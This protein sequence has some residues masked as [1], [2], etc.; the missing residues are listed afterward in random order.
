[1]RKALTAPGGRD[2]LATNKSDMIWFASDQDHWL[3]HWEKTLEER[4]DYP[5]FRENRK[6]AHSSKNRGLLFFFFFFK[7]LHTT[8]FGPDS[9]MEEIPCRFRYSSI[10]SSSIESTV[11]LLQSFWNSANKIVVILQQMFTSYSVSDRNPGLAFISSGL[12]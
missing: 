8:F 10:F 2:L 3:G 5:L 9:C 1:M 7:R 11:T 12:K 6:Q 4:T